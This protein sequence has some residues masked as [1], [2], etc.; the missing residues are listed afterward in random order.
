MDDASREIEAR[1]RCAFDRGDFGATATLSLDS[2]GPEIMRFLIERMRDE[3]VASEV[4][5][6]FVEDFWKG[7][8]GFA[9]RSSLR[10]WAYTLARN[11]AN[12]YARGPRRRQRRMLPLSEARGVFEVADRLRS[13]TLLHLRSAMKERVRDLR[14]A[15]SGDDQ[16][17]LTLRI[18]KQMSWTDIA[19]VLQE[20]GPRANSDALAVA[21]ARVRQRFASVKARL[22]RLA[23]RHGLLDG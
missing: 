13:E 19:Q 8:P 21:S 12:R 15:L 23:I 20:A 2:Y 3:H 10:A 11:A 4:F 9:W 6:Q 16:L 18:D 14:E 7:L 5:S 1:L 17:L 22:R